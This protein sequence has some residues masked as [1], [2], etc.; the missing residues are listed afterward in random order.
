MKSCEIE[1]PQDIIHV[2]GLSPS[3]RYI[4][5]HRF[6]KL[7]AKGIL[8]KWHIFTT[9]KMFNLEDISL[10]RL[11]NAEEPSNNFIIHELDYE[12]SASF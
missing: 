10:K 2:N 5:L 4:L 7:M 6:E 11:V 1:D 12:K 3:I 9:S 8:P